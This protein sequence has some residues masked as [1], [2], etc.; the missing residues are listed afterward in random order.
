VTIEVTDDGRGF[1]PAAAGDAV[2]SGLSIMRERVALL[3]GAFRVESQPGRGAIVRA[4]L[5]AGT[6][7]SRR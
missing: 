4:T 7:E 1:V 5:P 6:A 2:S 3:G